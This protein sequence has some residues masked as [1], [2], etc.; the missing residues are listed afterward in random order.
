MEEK[1]LQ[2]EKIKLTNEAWENL[3]NEEY[4]E[5]DEGNEIEIEIIK[6]NYDST[7]RHTEHHHLIF[8]RLSDDVYFKVKYE[9]SVKDSMGWEECNYGDTEAIE[10]FPYLVTITKY[11]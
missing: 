1:K 7:G 5:D 10:V 3:V 11:K 8:K 6:D 2:R 9:V 4:L